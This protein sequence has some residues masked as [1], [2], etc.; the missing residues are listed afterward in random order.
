MKEL[1]II[2]DNAI[3]ETISKEASIRGLTS[4]EY[5]KY[6]VGDF[7]KNCAANA[8]RTVLPSKQDMRDS[9]D[10]FSKDID[11]M[12]EDPSFQQI[13]K[14]PFLKAMAKEGSLSCKNCTMKL[15]SEDLEKGVCSK[16]GAEIKD[17]M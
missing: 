6:L 9:L 10:W 2:V 15:T 4:S 11:E 1:T 5:L 13:I 16:C 7:A 3:A 12:M 8:F 14:K 17:L